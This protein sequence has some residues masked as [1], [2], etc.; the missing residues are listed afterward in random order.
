MQR[1]SRLA[2]LKL[3]KPESDEQNGA[4]VLRYFAGEGAVC[5]IFSDEA[6]LLMERATGSLS[7]MRMA[8]SGDDDKAA[9]I[10]AGAI[11]KLHSPRSQ[12]P[13][14]KLPRL[15]DWFQALFAREAELPILARCAD[16]ARRLLRR[17]NVR[18]QSCMAI[19]IT[20]TSAP[21][22]GAGLPLIRRI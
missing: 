16:V 21:A 15:R 14:D 2:M 19:C 4:D 6:G 12:P 5:L 11:A 10:L 3:L 18:L 9:E 20:I 8:L 22:R 1:A 17:R 7:L 13:P